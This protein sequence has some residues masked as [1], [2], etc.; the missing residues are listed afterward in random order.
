LRVRTL[1][2]GSVRKTGNRVRLTARLIGAADGYNLW[3]QTYE[4]TLADVFAVQDELARAIAGNLTQRVA[5]GSIGPLVQ[6]PTGNLDAY[7]LYLRGRHAW[8]LASIDG[9]QTAVDCFARAVA[10]DPEYALAHAW[11]GYAN[12]VL[13]FDEFG[14]MSP[15]HALT[16][17][18][19]AANR[20]IQLDDSLGDAHFARALCA[21]LYEWD[22]ALAREEF[23]R[24]MN[25]SAVPA[26][27]Q[28]WYALF[29]CVSGHPDEALQ[30][31]RRA[32]TLD[33]LSLTVQ[34]T[35]GRCLYFGRRFEES[36]DVLRRHLER[37]PDSIQGHVTLHRSL[38]MADMLSEALQTL[39]RGINA[40][41]RVPL[42]LA[43]TGSIHGRLGQ[44]HQALALLEE[45]RVLGGRRHVPPAY[46]AEILFGL[47][48]LDEGSASLRPSVCSVGKVIRCRNLS[49]EESYNVGSASSLDHG[50]ILRRRS[51]HGPIAV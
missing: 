9:F 48:E 32:Q 51:I 41:G 45:L 34:V 26:L 11:L 42:L 50:C 5:S 17:A 31:A 8:S 33:P 37:N 2:E 28:H 13:G 18:R 19:A 27:V 20:A 30:V 1:L 44:R 6:P 10:V 24:A 43:C 7:T 47:G 15:T 35:V 4:R 29:L 12:A 36:I 25:A 22:W 49:I 14:V 16:K 21:L 40:I 3:S 46:R 38:R 23:E 39:E